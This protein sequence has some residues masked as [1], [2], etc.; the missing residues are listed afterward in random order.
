MKPL[1][2]PQRGAAL[3]AM[4]AVLVMGASWWLVTALNTPVNRTALHRSHNAEVLQQAK[5]ALIGWAAL[6]A[7]KDTE[8]N[9]GRLPCPEAAANIGNPSFEGTASGNCTL[10]AVGRLPWRTLGLDKLQDADGEPLWYV[11]SDGWAL[12]SSAAIMGINSNTRGNLAVDGQA[13]A[14]VALVIAPGAAL[15]LAPNALQ[16]AAGCVARTQARTPLAPDPLDYLECQNI[17]G[18]SLHTSVVDNASNPLFN[19][20][21]LAV[22]AAEVLA[23]VEGPVAARIQREVVPQLQSVYN[24]AAWGASATAPIFPFAAPFGDPAS[25]D[26]KGSAI[27]ELQGFIPVTAGT[28][29]ALTAG[30]CDASFVQW[31]TATINVVKR[32]GDAAIT[33][34][35]CA[36]STGGQVSCTISYSASCGGGLGSILGGSCSVTLEASVLASAQNIGR[37]MR[38]FDPA[39]ISGFTSLVSTST[40]IVGTGAANADVRGQL[41]PASCA[42]PALLC[43]LF[44]CSASSTATVTVPIAVFQDHPLLI[45]AATDPWYWFIANKW[46]D[47]TYYAIAPSHAPS[48][49]LHNCQTV[50][51]CIAVA[52]GTPPTNVRATLAL[53]GRSLT[54]T[55]GSNRALA[56]FLDTAENQ[57]VD[58]NFE[59]NKVS[60][61]FNDRF[62]TVS[63]Y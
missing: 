53:A 14:A 8:E 54:G 43:L 6:Q 20:Q 51:D 30:R 40:P 2:R 60:R 24:T 28:C 57:N 7:I 32:G 13:N 26:F 55:A 1:P 59:Q 49:A 3:L 29:N 37:A 34:V 41:P 4:L 61:G 33:S 47:V 50:A 38:T 31:N 44:P 58:R 62:I 42:C 19:D 36:A 45:P 11:V 5:Q 39:G 16:L 25:S 15:K 48:G 63:N 12:R 52:G 17:A 46:Y 27:G 21:A 35:N 23:A 18:A 10:P 22:T 56:D 9:P